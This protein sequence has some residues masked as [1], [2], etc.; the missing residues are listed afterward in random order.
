MTIVTVPLANLHTTLQ[1]QRVSAKIHYAFRC[2][3]CS[4]IQSAQDLVDA[5]AGPSFELVERYV[6]FSCVGRFTMGG[7]FKRGSQPGN[8]CNWT[9]G[10]LFKLHEFEVET[11]DGTRHPMFKPASPDEAQ[12]HERAWHLRQRLT[13][14]TKV[15]R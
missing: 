8:G 10:G 11:P 5:G 15:S 1:A 4:T 7:P 12:A 6:G 14:T 9:L 13:P 3:I 2:P